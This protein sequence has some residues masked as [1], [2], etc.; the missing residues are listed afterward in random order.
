MACVRT[1]RTRRKRPRSRPCIPPG[2]GSRNVGHIGSAH[3][4]AELEEASAEV[5]A[6]P[7]PSALTFPLPVLSRVLPLNRTGRALS[8]MPAVLSPG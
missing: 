3:N 5:H 1:V 2:A 8:E 6:L 7:F 4:G